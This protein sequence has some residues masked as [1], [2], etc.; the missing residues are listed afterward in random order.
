MS[1]EEKKEFNKDKLIDYDLVL[2]MLSLSSLVYNFNIDIKA[3][4]TKNNKYDLKNL[5]IENLKVDSKRKELLKQILDKSPNCELYKF[6][7][8][9][10]GSQVGITISHKQKRITFIFRGSNQLID[11]MHDFMICKKEISENIYVHLGFYKSLFKENLFNNLEEDLKKL[12]EEHSDYDL[13]I[14]GHSLGA[15]LTTLFGYLISDIIDKNITLITFASPRV[16]NKDW[17]NDFN[18][19]KNLRHFRFV[20][21][22]DI[23]TSIP[24]LYFYHVG[25]CILINKNNSMNYA[26]YNEHNDKSN[27]FYYF[28][29][30]DHLID[31]Y[32]NNLVICKWNNN[33]NYCENY[34]SSTKAEIVSE[35]NIELAEKKAPQNKSM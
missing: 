32:Y 10:S 9:E 4:S 33:N 26:K 22:K 21:E 17:A 28:N 6:Y 27:I 29:P 30:L 8:L 24:Y 14:T 3:E 1:Q 23:V 12:I 15:G 20:N 34:K 19:K 13:Y 2:D 35:E 31:N 7:D 18:K 5:N 16:G 11:W 25:N